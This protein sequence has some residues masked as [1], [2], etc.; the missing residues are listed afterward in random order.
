MAKPP[1]PE[2]SARARTR[3]ATPQFQP[4]KAIAEYYDPEYAHE[5]SLQHDVPFLLRQLP[6]KPQRLL[7][8]ACGTARAAIPLAQSGHRVTGVDYDPAM[9]AI[10]RRKRDFVGLTEAQLTLV[11]GDIT[12][13]RLP[14]AEATFDSCIILFNSL[15]A[16]TSLEQLDAVLETCRW[17]LRPGGRLFIDIFN[18]NLPLI[19]EAQSYGLD[20][21]TFHVPTLDRTVSRTA[22]IEDAT[23]I[24]G[25]RDV[26]RITFHYR[27]FENGDP[28]DEQVSFH[29][30][31][32][33]PRELHLLLERHGFKVEHEWGNYDGSPISRD[34]P[35]VMVMGRKGKCRC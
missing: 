18:P 34:A 27:W 1:L 24:R 23:D 30:T 6:T 22:D 33:M 5:E 9:L 32:I 8:L 20:P 11:R 3:P 16:F 12:R 21:I 14:T 35:R 31:W 28:H 7:E 10:A 25:G 26:R 2:N 29:T 13:L 15:L 19:A 4:Y 17:H